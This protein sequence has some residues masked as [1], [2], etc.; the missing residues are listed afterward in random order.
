MLTTSPTFYLYFTEVLQLYD[1]PDWITSC[2]AN[3]YLPDKWITPFARNLMI[4]CST[5]QQ[6][7]SI[8]VVTSNVMFHTIP[9]PP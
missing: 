5:D 6:T 1:R 2:L 7:H 3:T 4:A 9:L 8:T